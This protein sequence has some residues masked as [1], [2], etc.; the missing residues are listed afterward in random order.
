M[1]RYPSIPQDRLY[2]ERKIKWLQRTLPVR[3]EVYPPSANQ[4][5]SLAAPEATRVSKPVLSA[6]PWGPTSK[7]VNETYYEAVRIGARA[8]SGGVGDDQ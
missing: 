4:R 6:D 1:V 7:G 3:P 5:R 8:K 2:H